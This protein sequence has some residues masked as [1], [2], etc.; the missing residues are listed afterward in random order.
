MDPISV[1]LVDD[2]PTFLG[3]ATQ[4]LQQH[5]ELTVVGVVHGG[6]EAVAQARLL[7]PD[8]VLIDMAMPD[9]S[10]LE[11]I[12]HLREV[13]P[14]LGII[15]LTLYDT[16]AYRQAALMVGADD[17]VAKAA[18]HTHLL[19]AIRR[20]AL[21]GHTNGCNQPSRAGSISADA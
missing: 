21:P 1:L 9:L 18:M 7:C 6:R 8:I 13:N 16:D 15:A 11:V 4:F 5:D 10:G 12:P 19:P 2:S 3:I 17:F 20:L 14:E